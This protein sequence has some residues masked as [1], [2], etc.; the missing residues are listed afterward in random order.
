MS[1]TPLKTGEQLSLSRFAKTPPSLTF[2][3]GERAPLTVTNAVVYL[4]DWDEELRAQVF[5]FEKGA[6]WSLTVRVGALLGKQVNPET[7]TRVV[8]KYKNGR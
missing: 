6:L 4:I 7:V 1:F 8:R 5:A 2:T 3:K